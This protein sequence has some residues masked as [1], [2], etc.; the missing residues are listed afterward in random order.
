VNPLSSTLAWLVV[1]PKPKWH[2]LVW[3]TACAVLCAICAYSL[4]STGNTSSDA[5]NLLTRARVVKSEGVLHRSRLADGVM[6]VEGDH[7]QTE[8][9]SVALSSKAFVEFDLGQT[10]PISA[11]LLQGDN[12]DTYSLMVSEN[13]A[14][15]RSLWSA[16]PAG[17][18]GLRTRSTSSLSAKGRYVKLTFGPGDTS[19]SVAEVAVFAQTPA[20]FPPRVSVARGVP[21]DEALR[22]KLMLFGG[23]LIAF[24]LLTSRTLPLWWNLVCLVLPL[25]GCWDLWRGLGDAWP[26]GQ[27]EIS[28]LRGVTGAVSAVVVLREVFLP[29]AFGWIGHWA[30]GKKRAAPTLHGHPWCSVGILGVCAFLALGTFGNLGHPQFWDHKFEQPSRVHNFDMRVY[31]PV[32]K[33]FKEL[34]Y[35]G[36][37]QAS[38][39]AYVDDTPGLTLE[40]VGHVTMRDLKTHEMSRTRDVEGA[41]RAVKARFSPERWR[42]FVRD[43]RYFR[44]TMGIRDYLGS[45]HDHGGNATP[46]W[47]VVAH[48]IFMKTQASNGVLLMGA[49]LDPLL[50]IAAFIAI[51]RVFG[52]RTMLLSMVVFG[53][54]DYYMFGSNWFG[55]TLRHD[56]MALLGFGACALKREKWMLGGALLAW[57][58]MIRAFPALALAAVVVPAVFWFSEQRRLNGKFPGL[59]AIWE[60]QQPVI[61][62]LAGA[63][64]WTV[65]WF[66]VS[67]AMLGFGAWVQWFHK[68][69][70]LAT[71]PHVNHVSLRALVAYDP[72]Y[73]FEGLAKVPPPDTADWGVWQER[74]FF[75]R[76]GLFAAIVVVFAGMVA[77]AS[78]RRKLEHATI[79]GL[80]MIPIV[81]YPANY[82]AHF[83]FLLP[84]VA[85]ERP[86]RDPTPTTPGG[87]FVWLAVTAMCA[88]LYWTTLI[89]DLDM[90]FNC[91]SLILVVTLALV[92]LSL[93]VEDYFQ[94]R[95][96]AKALA[97]AKKAS[98][99]GKSQ[100]PRRPSGRAPAG[101]QPP[102]TAPAESRPEAANEPSPPAEPEPLAESKSPTASETPATEASPDEPGPG[103]PG[104]DEP[105]PD[106]P[107]P[108]EHQKG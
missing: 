42:E 71:G 38:V 44:E 92:L 55:A 81:F 40:G 7:W 22:D 76:R 68:V 37:Y 12:N 35:D 70:L 9:T 23:L 79:L 30:L 80:T 93:I 84:L 13:G 28:L 99:P 29:T 47:M 21:A 62:T 96:P 26:P 69:Q 61:R 11:A 3:L 63:A 107:G 87:G 83:V 16:A 56:W 72:R 46:V 31:Y 15:W 6:A 85:V 103:E 39:M 10:E 57:S 18:P 95:Q 60:K 94:H 74:M 54:N 5:V 52:I 48:L 2:R 27:R 34:Q 14:E 105:G 66:A 25:F 19:F 45:M 36:L 90:H 86:W 20:V 67:T 78:S 101:A 8:L 64:V 88:V 73:T 98:A 75:A 108:G 77:S 89:K 41:I 4:R 50:L 49:L 97:T 1:W 24:S 51:G 104:P 100:R 91:A 58:A 102:R 106:E 59:R 33:Y 17:E 43:M 82:Y 53:A 65:V 32:A